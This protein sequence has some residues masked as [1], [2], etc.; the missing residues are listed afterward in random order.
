M[1]SIT[2][3]QGRRNV[4]SGPND[5]LHIS[6]YIAG[7]GNH[8]YGCN[9]SFGPEMIFL[10][11]WKLVM[12]G[13]IGGIHVW[14]KGNT[15]RNVFP[16]YRARIKTT[17]GIQ[18]LTNRLFAEVYGDRVQALHILDCHNRT[19]VTLQNKQIKDHET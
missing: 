13:M 7:F 16:N 17:R 19:I 5:R 14:K 6:D 4:I 8:N 3:F 11:T 18:A 1:P 2:D 12:D 9:L 15:Y 10:L